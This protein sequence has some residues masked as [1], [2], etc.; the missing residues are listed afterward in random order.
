MG[1]NMEKFFENIG[2]FFT[3]SVVMGPGHLNFIIGKCPKNVSLDVGMLL[4]SAQHETDLCI[5]KKYGEAD[6]ALI[7]WHFEPK[8]KA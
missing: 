7:Y 6:L 4:Y 3:Y 8:I 2:V 1:S 5:T